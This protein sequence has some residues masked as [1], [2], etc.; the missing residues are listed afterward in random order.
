MEFS[1]RIMKD[2]VPFEQWLF[3]SQC[4]KDGVGD[5]LGREIKS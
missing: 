2:L 4:R 5:D 3:Y 1:F